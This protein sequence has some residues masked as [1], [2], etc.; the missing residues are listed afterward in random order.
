[1]EIFTLKLFLLLTFRDIEPQKPHSFA[2]SQLIY[3]TTVVCSEFQSTQ[4]CYIGSLMIYRPACLSTFLK[5]LI[6]FPVSIETCFFQ[7]SMTIR[8]E[9]K[10]GRKSKFGPKTTW[11]RS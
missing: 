2:L 7:G 4:K 10:L 8:T 1:M 5:I 11:D 6:R 9:D 3:H